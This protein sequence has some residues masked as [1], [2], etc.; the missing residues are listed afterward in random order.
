MARILKEEKYPDGSP[1]ARE[2]LLD[3]RKTIVKE[4]WYPS[5]VD[6]TAQ[7]RG[8]QQKYKYNIVNGQEHGLQEIWYENGQRWSKHNYV[9]G[10]KHGVQEFWYPNG[11]LK[12]KGN[13]VNGQRHGLREE[14]YRNGQQRYKKYY[15]DGV[16]KSQQAYQTYIEKLTPEIQATTD[17]EER[18]SNIIAEYL[19]P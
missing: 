2:T 14:W 3:D 16:E 1:K 6:P 17:F 8:G 18:L 12:D 7:R 10:Q 4:A 11:Q 9:D 5:G 15:L 19:L 13:Y